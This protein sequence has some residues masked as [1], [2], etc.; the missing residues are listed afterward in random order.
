MA[1]HFQKHSI[2]VGTG[3]FGSVYTYRDVFLPY[4]FLCLKLKENAME[5][6]RTTALGVLGFWILALAITA[7]WAQD[8]CHSPTECNLTGEDACVLQSGGSC[9][10]GCDISEYYCEDCVCRYRDDLSGCDCQLPEDGDHE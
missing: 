5:R 7:V 4:D 3:R 9:H 6:L 2:S 10:G 1:I 8:R